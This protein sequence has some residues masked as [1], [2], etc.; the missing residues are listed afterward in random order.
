MGPLAEL[1]DLRHVRA[2]PIRLWPD[3]M[4]LKGSAFIASVIT[5]G[6]IE[7]FA[8]PKRLIRHLC[9]SSRR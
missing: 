2:N 4:F 6:V 7:V 5:Q 8:L 9:H 3:T 1:L